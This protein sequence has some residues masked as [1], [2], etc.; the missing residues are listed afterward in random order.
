GIAAGT[1]IYLEGAGDAGEVKDGVEAGILE[2]PGRRPGGG[3]GDIVVLRGADHGHGVGVRVQVGHIDAGE[4]DGSAETG[5]G[6]IGGQ[7]AVGQVDRYRPGGPAQVDDG[8][9]AVHDAVGVRQRADE[10]ERVHSAQAVQ[11]EVLDGVGIKQNRLKNTERLI[12]FE[13][14]RRAG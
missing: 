1:A 3:V 9:A 14:L 11:V 4:G 8:V 13:D 10:I 2:S 6:R 7:G 12:R 5:N